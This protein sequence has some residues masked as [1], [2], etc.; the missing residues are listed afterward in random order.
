M[1]ILGE[2]FVENCIEIDILEVTTYEWIRKS[3][4]FSQ[5]FFQPTILQFV[6]TPFQTINAYADAHIWPISME[7]STFLWLYAYMMIHDEFIIRCDL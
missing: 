5:H 7:I 1:C 2:Q 6:Q 3:S 4:V